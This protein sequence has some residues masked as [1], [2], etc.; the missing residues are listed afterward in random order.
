MAWPGLAWEAITDDC[1]P[2][3]LHPCLLMEPAFLVQCQIPYISILT[4]AFCESSAA[5]RW[6]YRLFDL[7]RR[8]M[9]SYTACLIW[10]FCRMISYCMADLCPT[11]SFDLFWRMMILYCSMAGLCTAF[12]CD[13]PAVY[14]RRI[15]WFGTPQAPPSYQCVYYLQPYTSWVHWCNDSLVKFVTVKLYD[16]DHL[17]YLLAYKQC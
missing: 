11:I 10:F 3:I 16:R 6:R 17:W 9:I 7:F 5:M 15:S 8:V 1:I 14:S 2:T 4:P 13:C 12:W